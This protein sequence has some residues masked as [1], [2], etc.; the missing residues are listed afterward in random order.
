MTTNMSAH[1]FKVTKQQAGIYT[2]CCDYTA[3]FYTSREFGLPNSD[4]WYITDVNGNSV[5]NRYATL[6]ECKEQMAHLHTNLLLD[7]ITDA[8]KVGA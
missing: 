3:E 8:E 7:F 2:S 4:G 1:K 5:L 6:K